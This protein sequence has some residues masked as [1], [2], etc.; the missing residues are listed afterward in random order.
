MGQAGIIINLVL[1]VLN[2]LPVPPLDGG[3]VISGLLPGP[4]AV[5]YN[6]VE[7]YGLLVLLLLLAS[8]ALAYIL[9]PPIYSL[10]GLIS[11]VFDLPA[12]SA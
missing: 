2:L 6:R 3:R 5:K 9:G 4:M 8:G 11:T 7:P 12:F 10:Y 1:M